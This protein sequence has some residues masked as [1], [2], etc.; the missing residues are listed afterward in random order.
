[1][2]TQ[3]TT[4]EGDR[5][6]TIALKAY[7]EQTRFSIIQAVNPNVPSTDVFEGGIRLLIPII[8]DNSRFENELLPSFRKTIQVHF[9]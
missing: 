3:Y 7:G 9:R 5:W 4:I 8:E 1:M 6:D 2:F